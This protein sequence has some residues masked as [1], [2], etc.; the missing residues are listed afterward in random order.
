[1][2]DVIRDFA[3]RTLCLKTQMFQCNQTKELWVFRVQVQGT[4]E[5]N[6]QLGF[7]VNE[8]CECE[9]KERCHQSAETALAALFSSNKAWSDMRQRQTVDL[10]Y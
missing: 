1:M 4:L 6:P 9:C 7:F 2:N 5:C 3:I 8:D 10:R